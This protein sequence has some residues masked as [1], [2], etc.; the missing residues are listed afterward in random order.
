MA[1]RK[2][3]KKATKE[4]VKKEYTD[5]EN[6]RIANLKERIKR[7]PVKVKA[8]NKGQ[9]CYI[10]LQD[11][12]DLLN[13]VKFSEAMGTTDLDLQNHLLNQVIQTFKGTGLDG[14]KVA[15][16]SNCTLSTLSGIQPQDEI[17]AMLAVQMIGVHNMAMDCLGRASR[18]D[19]VEFLRT[20]MNGAAKLLRTFV[21]Q[22]EALKKNRTG[23]QQKMVVEHVHVNKGGQ[24]IV[25]NVNQG[26]GVNN[27][28]HE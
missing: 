10:K 2:P 3:A 11:P 26:G 1:K 23:G 16:A 21:A 25:G 5:E 6:T 14:D 22:M 24:A 28:N 27:K 15:S 19:N 20:Y 4:L 8:F 18:T 13:M 9:N 7:G 17:E 12:D